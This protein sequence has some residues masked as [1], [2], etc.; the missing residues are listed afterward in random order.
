M[1]RDSPPGISY[2]SLETA[3]GGHKNNTLSN[4]DCPCARP[5]IGG[6][7]CRI[8]A[9]GA[10]LLAMCVDARTAKR[11]KCYNLLHFLRVIFSFDIGTLIRTIIRSEK[12]TRL[13]SVYRSLTRHIKDY[14]YP[15]HVHEALYLSIHRFRIEHSPGVDECDRTH[16]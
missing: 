6:K 3:R 1:T 12:K 5:H 13:G 9:P 7:A 14:D 8:T 2:C 11:F 10:A 15:W 4:Q 16:S